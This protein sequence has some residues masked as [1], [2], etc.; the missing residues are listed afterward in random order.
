[1]QKI[2][3]L[4]FERNFVLLPLVSR[5]VVLAVSHVSE[6]LLTQIHVRSQD[7]RHPFHSNWYCGSGDHLSTGTDRVMSDT[8]SAWVLRRV[9]WT[10]SR[11]D[12]TSALDST[13]DRSLVPLCLTF[14]SSKDLLLRVRD[15]FQSVAV[16]CSYMSDLVFLWKFG[17]GSGFQL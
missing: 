5:T 14:T 7:R 13:S 8:L 9:L 1:M 4:A 3:C 6:Q 12:L 2:H 16:R 15:E 10:C 17:E 11:C